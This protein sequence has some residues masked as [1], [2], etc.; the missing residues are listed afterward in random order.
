MRFDF[1][2]LLMCLAM[3][4]P[5]VA[6]SVPPSN[7]AG[8][9][10]VPTAIVFEQASAGLSILCKCS[11]LHG[12]RKDR[13]GT[14]CG[15]SQADVCSVCCGAGITPIFSQT[16]WAGSQAFSNFQLL[17]GFFAGNFGG[18]EIPPP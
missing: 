1:S 16:D 8:V 2:V 10:T 13:A 6:A 7:R 14:Q 11:A 15:C 5:V 4:G 12:A 3:A 17:A 18:P 9:A